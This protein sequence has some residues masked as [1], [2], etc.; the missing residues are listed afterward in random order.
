MDAK[1]FVVG[2]LAIKRGDGLDTES[3]RNICLP[4][5]LAPN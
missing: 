1:D 5:C 3:Y 2:T 4:A